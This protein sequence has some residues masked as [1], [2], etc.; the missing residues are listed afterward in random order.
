[1]PPV[2]TLDGAAWLKVSKT[3]QNLPM[4]QAAPKK[5]V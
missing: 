3:N 4:Y 1:M 2:G 5:A